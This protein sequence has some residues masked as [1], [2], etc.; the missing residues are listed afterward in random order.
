MNIDLTKLVTSHVEE[1][2]VSGEVV[3]PRALLDGTQVRNLKDTK[4][5]G[6]IVKLCDGDYQISGNLTGIMV[7]PDD[8]TLED[9]DIKFDS[10]IEENFSGNC[11]QEEKNLEIIQNR[12]DI[13]EFLWQNILVE[14]PLKVV[15]EKNE[16]L[17]MEGNGWR[18][19]TEEE[20]ELEKSNNSPFSELSK[21]FDSRKE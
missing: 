15:S 10:V 5:D 20:L 1:I 14:I 3:I 4:F 13:T 9:V 18:L 16:G 21:M 12:L 6:S 17:T 8:I 2:L 11:K 19:I 7:L